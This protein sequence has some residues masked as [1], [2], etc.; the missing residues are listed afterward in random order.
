MSIVP[1]TPIV[2]SKLKYHL[3]NKLPED[4]YKTLYEKLGPFYLF[5]LEAS[6]RR[7]G[8]PTE[9]VL[10][11]EDLLE[12]IECKENEWDCIDTALNMHTRLKTRLFEKNF[13][14]PGVLRVSLRGK[15]ETPGSV[16]FDI[17]HDE[18]PNIPEENNVAVLR[19]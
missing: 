9:E 4:E 12:I 11:E 5:S 16:W 3:K 8:Y 14:N 10:A 15:V 18:L 2:L 1:P 17:H 13:G 7:F 6:Y 19:A